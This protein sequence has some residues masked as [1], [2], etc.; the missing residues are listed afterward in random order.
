MLIAE[1]HKIENKGV[2]GVSL[3]EQPIQLRVKLSDLERGRVNDVGCVASELR[4]SLALFVDDLRT[5]GRRRKR[6]DAPRFVISANQR[7][8]RGFDKEDLRIYIRVAFGA[9]SRCS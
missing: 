6:M 9:P 8:V 4:E 3:R 2:V 1:R 5:D 7:F